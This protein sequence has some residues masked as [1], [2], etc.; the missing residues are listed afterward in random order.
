MGISTL[1]SYC[2]AQIFEAIGLESGVRRSLLHAH[3]VADRR[4]R[5]RRRSPRKSC[6]GTTRAFPT[7]IR[8]ARAIS[9]PGGEYQWRRDGEFHLF[10]PDTV[11]KL[12]H[13]TRSGQYRVYQEYT[14]LVND[15]S[16]T[17]R[18]AARAA[19]LQAHAAR[20]LP[21]DEV[22]PVESIVK[23][24]ATGAMSYGSISQEAHETLAIAMNRM[25]GEVEHAARAARI[26][27]GTSRDANGD[28]RR[29]AIK[30]VASARFGVTSEYLVNADDLQIK[31]AQ[32][33][34]PGEGGQLP[35]PK[36]YPWIAKVRHST[37]GVTLHLA[38]A[39]SRHLL[40]RGSRAAD[41]TT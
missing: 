19:G 36:V 13:A 33:A 29:S 34:K 38:A 22:E 14:T 18:H 39:A 25:G 11:F 9:T 28:S 40:D 31:M 23:R 6:S 8:R 26:R 27:R 3:G 5:P 20:R 21:L 24:F 15:Q 35:G 17:A 16:R 32:G 1:Q 37:P 10:N 12:Q 30:Q 2:G 4:R 41:S 7:R